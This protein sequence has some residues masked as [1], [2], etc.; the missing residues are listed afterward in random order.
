MILNLKKVSG[1]KD[2]TKTKVLKKGLK[3]AEE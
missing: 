3:L 1:Q 2:Q